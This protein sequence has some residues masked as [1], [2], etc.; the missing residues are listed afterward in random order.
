MLADDSYDADLGVFLR[1]REF[2]FAALLPN[3]TTA[4]W[5]VLF[6]PLPKV[7]REGAALRTGSLGCLVILMCAAL[8]ASGQAAQ[9]TLSLDQCIALA[10]GAPSSVR[11]AQDQLRGAKF[12]VRGAKAAFLPNLSIQNTFTYN[13]PLLY[14]PNQF[15]F[16]ALNGVREYTSVA[17]SSLEVDSS[18]RLRALYDRADANRQAAEASVRLSERD[19][20]RS[21]SMSYYRLLL[22]RRLAQTAN[23]NWRT[24]RDFEDRVNRL[25]AGG[26]ASQ[27]D[28]TKASLEATLLERTVH[29]LELEAE[30]AN[31]DLASFW[32]ADTNSHLDLVDVLDE[33]PS[34]TALIEV[35]A[36]YLNRPELAIFQAEKKGFEADSRRARSQM[37]PQLNLN[38]L[39]GIDATHVTSRDRGYAGF[40]H[41]NIPVFDF[42]KARSEQQQ[43]RSLAAQSQTDFQIGQRLFS[44]EYQDALSSVRDTFAQIAIADRAVALAKDNLRL[45]RLRF[46]GGEGPALDV[47]TAQSSLVQ[48]QID[49][50]TTRANYLNAQL[51]LKVASGR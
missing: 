17:N 8:M 1:L 12:G 27:A 34:S 43:F 47:V 39:Y 5:S 23:E 6:R 44:K 41:F 48:A 15:S 32:T 33:P 7:H 51:A 49:Y 4:R 2:E 46:E 28:L 13:S 18:G 42:L 30:L 38:F 45:S 35:P 16:V 19:L 50:Y 26:E 22:T 37:F 31:H 25:V 9:S 11:R 36:S 21:V 29:S 24:A 3:F 20:E 14:D 10:K 40:V